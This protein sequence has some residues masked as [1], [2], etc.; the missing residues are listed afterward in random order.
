MM[1]ASWCSIHPLWHDWGKDGS[2]LSS[3]SHEVIL[4][5]KDEK[6]QFQIFFFSTSLCKTIKKKRTTCSALSAISL[7][8]P[9]ARV[10]LYFLPSR[11]R[12]LLSCFR[13]PLRC[14]GWPDWHCCWLDEWPEGGRVPE[15]HVV[16]PRAVLLDVQW[17]HFCRAGQVSAVEELGWAYTGPGGGRRSETHLHVMSNNAWA[18]LFFFTLLPQV[19]WDVSVFH[20]N[21]FPNI[22]LC[23]QRCSEQYFWS[24][25]VAPE[26]CGAYFP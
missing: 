13:P 14:F 16:Q 26:I 21:V 4:S 20:R 6:L 5:V 1:M 11:L 18:S 8:Q 12:H 19:I 9:L 22:S 25:I 23:F 17:D 10:F 24:D 2:T 15:R 7:P 3:H